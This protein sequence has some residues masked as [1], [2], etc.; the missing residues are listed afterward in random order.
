MFYQNI[1]ILSATS[2]QDGFQFHCTTGIYVLRQMSCKCPI[3]SQHNVNTNTSISINHQ[4][5]IH[6]YMYL[7]RLL[8]MFISTIQR[9]TPGCSFH[10]YS[11][12]NPCWPTWTKEP[13]CQWWTIGWGRSASPEPCR[14]ATQASC[15]THP[16]ARGAQGIRDDET[17]TYR[18]TRS[19]SGLR[20]V[21]LNL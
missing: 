9:T 19:P 3:N 20:L 2:C 15:G 5:S 14:H 13:S 12:S 18:K 16:H 10:F 8:H 17:G 11:N 21:F 7:Y 6:I 1:E 4:I